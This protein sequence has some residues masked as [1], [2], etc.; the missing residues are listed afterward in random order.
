MPN[1]FLED[2]VKCRGVESRGCRSLSTASEA[3]VGISRLDRHDE[4]WQ[5]FI[6][7]TSAVRGYFGAS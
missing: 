7:R 6:A 4:Y 2:R 3:L 5:I 1:K